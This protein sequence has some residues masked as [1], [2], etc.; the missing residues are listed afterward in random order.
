MHVIH[1][2]E[3]AAMACIE[4]SQGSTDEHAAAG[5]H[6]A[7]VAAAAQLYCHEPGV[8]YHCVPLE[9]VFD[10]TPEAAAGQ[11][12]AGLQEGQDQQ[13]SRELQR[14]QLQHLLAAVSDTTGRQDLV[15]HLRTHLLL[16][17][18]AALGCCRMARGDCSTAL[19]ARVVAAAAK[20]CGYSLAG[21]VRLV[22]ARCAAVLAVYLLGH[23][24][25][26]AT[27]AGRGACCRHA[28]VVYQGSL[29]LL[30]LAAAGTAARCRHASC[31]FGRC[32]PGSWACSALTCACRWP[33]SRQ[34]S[35]RRGKERPRRASTRWLMPL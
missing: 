35:V 4:P 14:R 31:P 6:S 5:G 10:G 20:G 30:L 18:A 2:D 34:V 28:A 15:C 22:D 29:P 8:Q 9:A 19:A 11:D 26:I 33:G 27:C 7:S 17:T 13:Q 16:R 23:H 25:M 24:C 32:L 21:D 1:I 12:A 3:S